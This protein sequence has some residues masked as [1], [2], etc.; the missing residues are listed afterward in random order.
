MEIEYQRPLKG[1]GRQ[2]GKDSVTLTQGPAPLL[3]GR[4]EARASLPYRAAQ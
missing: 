3:S 2:E 1:E 4:R